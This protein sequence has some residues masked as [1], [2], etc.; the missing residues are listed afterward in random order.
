[1]TG[2]IAY[3]F[4]YGFDAEHYGKVQNIDNNIIIIIKF[5]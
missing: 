1:M 5:V 2:F 3:N 4:C